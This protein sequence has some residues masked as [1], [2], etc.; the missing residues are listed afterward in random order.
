MT[1]IIAI[2]DR[3]CKIGIIDPKIELNFELENINFRLEEAIPRPIG[4][5]W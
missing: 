5:Y 1:P 4:R 3:V 2:V